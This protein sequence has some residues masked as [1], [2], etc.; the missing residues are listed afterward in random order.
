MA[1]TDR[2][3]ALA[4]GNVVMAALALHG[5]LA[6]APA[7][8]E[9]APE[10]GVIALRYLHYKDQQDVK[11]RYPNYSGTEGSSFKRITAKSPSVYVMAP[12][13]SDWTIEASAV[14]DEVSG[15]TPRNYSDVSGATPKPGMND[16]RKAGDVR[17]SRHFSRGGVSV[18]ASHSEE[19]DY[20]ST[21]V[22]IEGRIA[23]ADNNTTLTVGLG[24][25]EDTINPV[26]QV[27]VNEAKRT[28]EL[29]VGVTQALT[30][31]DLVQLNVTYADGQGYFSD[32]YKNNDRRPERRKQAAG[33]VRWN[34]FVGAL[35]ATARA[36][37]RY[38]QDSFGIAAHTVEA[39]WVQPVTRWLWVTPSARY[40]TQS[41][42][43]FYYD[44][45]MD[46]GYYPGPIV[47]QAFSTTDQRLSA[48]GAVTLGL[49][50]EVRWADWT[51]DVKYERYE[52]RGN[53]RS[54]GK[55]SP[56]VDNFQADSV[57][58]GVSRK[59]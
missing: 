3:G 43:D 53:W 33:L 6:P 41:S 54:F 36:G 8:A 50:A 56:N 1:A 12:I 30:A 17:I 16:Y 21:A 37:Y 2:T 51:G 22:S 57:Q 23:T 5:G 9:T 35:D 31:N 26:N 52:Q 44:P 32:P 20:R 18:G 45:V 48:F 15:A 59:F 27:V 14:T 39:A 34:H 42:A 25:A 19:H 24:H 40:Y 4:Y 28:N 46:S 38:Y 29:I 47:P 13:G 7:L 55:G 10:Q 58:V 11:V 49:K